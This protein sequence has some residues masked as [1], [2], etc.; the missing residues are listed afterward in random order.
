MSFDIA[1]TPT[2]EAVATRDETR[3]AADLKARTDAA[4][5]QANEQD[6]VRR[7]AEAHAAAGQRLAKLR[8]AERRLSQYA[9]EIDTRLGVRREA[10]LDGLIESAASEAKP[11]FKALNEVS[12]WEARGRIVSRAIERLVET[13][14]PIAELN[15][16]REE[17]HWMAAKSRALE[18]IAQERAEKLLG[19]MREAVSE[20][21][22]LPVDMSK[23]VSGSLLAYAAEFRDRAI[24]I[25]GNADRIEKVYGL[26][27]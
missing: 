21:M 6:D 10:A 3:L 14:I 20:E 17:A 18:R 27:R 16:L 25:S 9:K 1:R 13:L 7:S 19:Q 24:Q 2:L 5:A 26:S 23:G 12:A 11:E 22:V 4:V 15:S 8:M